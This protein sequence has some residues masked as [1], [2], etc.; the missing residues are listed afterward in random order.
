MKV[1]K[2]F[3][4]VVDD[5]L[6][7]GVIVLTD[8]QVRVTAQTRRMMRPKLGVGSVQNPDGKGLAFMTLNKARQLEAEGDLDI[9]TIPDRGK[10]IDMAAIFDSIKVA[11]DKE[12]RLG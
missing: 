5:G 8:E 1:L 4:M 6:P 12:V 3:K 2:V 9:T 10:N 7:D 11:P